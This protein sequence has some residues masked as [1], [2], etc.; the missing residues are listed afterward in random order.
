[1][2][3]VTYDDFLIVQ[4]SDNCS[5][6]IQKEPSEILET[7]FDIY[8]PKTTIEKMTNISQPKNIFTEAQIFFDDFK[9]KRLC[10][11]IHIEE[12]YIIIE[13]SDVTLSHSSENQKPKE[14]LIK[15]S[16][17]HYEN[18]LSFQEL[19]DSI[20]QSVKDIS[21]FDR[22]LIYKFDNDNNGTVLSE[23]SENFDESLMG[24][25]FPASD[26]PLQARTLYIKNRFRQIEDANEKNAVMIPTINRC[27]DAPLDMSM[28]YLRSVS[29]VH[30]EYLKNMGVM[31]SMSISIVI[32]GKLWG[33]IA[34][35]HK[36][37]K[38]ISLPN[39]DIYYLLSS[40]FSY[41]IQEKEMLEQYK[42]TTTLQLKR[43]L[44]INGLNQYSENSFQEALN[45]E[46]K[47]LL[48]VIVCDEVII[49]DGENIIA[50]KSSLNNDEILKVHSIANEND[51]A[52]LFVS[53][54]LGISYPE[55]LNFSQKLGGI[56][57]VRF[58]TNKN[59][60][61]VFLKYEQIY[62]VLWAGN[63]NKQVEFIDGVMVINP[64]ASFESWKEVVTGSSSLFLNEEI[65][66]IKILTQELE[67]SIKLFQKYEETKKIKEE[68]LAQEMI[69]LQQS[70]MASM[71]EMVGNI[72][73]QWRQ[74]LSLISTYATGIMV[75]KEHGLLNDEVL[76]ESCE[77]INES[78][79]R[80][81]DIIT[82]FRNYLM[83]T[84]ELKD[85]VLQDILNQ[86]LEIINV[87]L[88]DN[89]I[90]LKRNIQAQEPIIIQMVA[91]E[92]SEVIINI[93][94]NAKDI[95]LENEVEN[96]W[97]T[98]EFLKTDNNIA[99]T[100]EDNGGGVPTEVMPRIFEQY[101]TTKD[102]AHGTGIGLY[103][104]YQIVTESL[105]GKIYV[106]NTENGA[107]FFIEIPIN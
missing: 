13:V 45:F 23:V 101:F 54:N 37:S 50:K 47:H 66:S 31:A 1:M 100:I 49:I 14:S 18:A 15:K 48:N 93:I 12:H 22:V 24:H 36:T 74:P 11:A 96:P 32:G 19:I 38:R 105:K 89:G 52:T 62:S 6:L 58:P 20:G 33:L 83:A 102:K 9:G 16:I 80:L 2:F 75:K 60:S 95:L 65:S 25:R 79:Q 69:M 104:S 94:N 26:I 34:C 43:E 10:F 77:K 70:K 44:F 7:S 90:T 51:E 27:T 71:G 97:I 63:P 55:V 88:L 81:S 56:L 3:V 99:I 82:V 91:G 98:V 86:S 106:Q 78:T 61:I 8:F 39:F 5:C 85:V 72:I 35:H 73:H 21:G 68:K 103:M 92:L 57:A 59:M 46:I 87:T 64:R 41:Q 4:V 28:C 40:I 30:I 29:P 42:L 67:L 76:H 84:K 17:A 53:S 107:K